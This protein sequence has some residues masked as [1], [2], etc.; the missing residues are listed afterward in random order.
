M[1]GASIPLPERVGSVAFTCDPLRLG[2]V[3]GELTNLQIANLLWIKAILTGGAHWR[4]PDLRTELVHPPATGPALRD[5]IGNDAVYG[6]YLRD[7]EGVWA[8]RFDRPSRDVFHAVVNGL[9]R[10]D[11][12]V[13]FE[14]PPSLR[15]ELNARRVPYLNLYV[16]ALRFLRDLCFGATTNCSGLRH[17]LYAAVVPQWE[18]D[19][20]AHRFRAT[21]SR[22]D[23]PAFSIPPGAPV[24]I[25]QTER[26]SVL[27]EGGRFR[28]WSDYLEALV[29][30][31]REHDMV[32]LLEHPMRACSADIARFL[33]VRVGKTVVA[34]NANGYGV[35]MSNDSIPFAV[36]LSSSLGVEASALGIETSFL[37]DDP[38]RRFRLP[39]IEDGLDEAL[40]HALLADGF[41]SRILGTRESAGKARPR[42]AAP[43]EPFALGPNHVRTSLESW[44]YRLLESGAGQ[45][46]SR[47]VVLPAWRL[48]STDREAIESR[49]RARP[50]ASSLPFDRTVAGTGCSNVELLAGASCIAPG[51]SRIL[52]L[53]NPWEAVSIEGFNTHEQWGCWMAG[54]VA[55]IRIGCA[56]AAIERRA[57]I[58]VTLA[59]LVSD[60]IADRYPVLRVE[61]NREARAY[62]LFGPGPRNTAEVRLSVE[63]TGEVCELE[64]DFTAAFRPIDLGPSADTRMLGCAVT[65]VE[66]RCEA[67][68]VCPAGTAGE[69][70]IA[71]LTFPGT[72]TPQASSGAAVS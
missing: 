28:G 54:T 41:W 22:L 66:V 69:R 67:E 15:Y 42:S 34:T 3:E 27:I 61:A 62:V 51:E 5:A 21:F 18:V 56:A 32:V 72:D 17:H 20:Q 19:A 31:L 59:V 68:T 45:V 48:A 63:V 16:H 7:P 44:S 40:G 12:V 25:G 6:D 37:L 1:S 2:R 46:S 64:L 70:R 71:P 60:Q 55:A 49:L 57:R 26:D 35:L 36:T 24:L 29:E 50:S 4:R 10:F 13:G 43:A 58:H 53:G 30:R 38:R 52:D 8:S 9:S 33:R 65:R 14:L 47:K 39:A 11:L 23:S